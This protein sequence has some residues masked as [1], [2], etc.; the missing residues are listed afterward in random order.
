MKGMISDIQKFSLHD[1]PG[2]R[3]TVFLK[4]CNMKCVWCHNPEAISFSPQIAEYPAKCIHCESCLQACTQ[5]AMQ[6]K[7]EHVTIN[8]ELCNLCGDCVEVCPS[9]AITL[10]GTNRDCNDVFA[11]IAADI[12]YYRNSGGGI[13]I[14]GGEPLMQVDFCTE[15]LRLCRKAGFDTAIETNL[16]LPY[17]RIER[18]LPWTKRIFFDLKIMDD[19]AHIKYTGVSNQTVLE[20]S[21]KLDQE[22]IPFV[23][24]TPLIPGITDSEENIFAIASWLRTFNNLSYY[25]LLNYNPLAAAKYEAIGIEYSLAS[26][27]PLS[28]K[29]VKNLAQVAMQVGVK[30]VHIQ[31]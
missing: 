24:R 17:E 29:A 16:S 9:G 22:G 6:R 19:T 5:S 25:E 23:V 13:T 20:N 3:T 12:P 18:V 15:L 7:E 27:K 11:E 21:K 14:S 10:I 2:I 26:E 30:V 31:E 1:G 28:K 4:G 8:R